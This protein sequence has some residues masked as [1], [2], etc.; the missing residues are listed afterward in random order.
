MKQGREFQEF[1]VFRYCCMHNDCGK[2][3]STKVN[4]K[5]HIL[6]SHVKSKRFTCERC[7][8][9]F[10]SKQNLVEHSYMH[11]GEKPYECVFC[12]ERF[13]H[14]SSLSLHYKFHR[15]GMPIPVISLQKANDKKTTTEEV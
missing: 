14:I 10:A 1:R 6:I 9:S 8:R 15:E 4:L 12:K 11:S 7:D 3:Y 13:R 5:R 2:E